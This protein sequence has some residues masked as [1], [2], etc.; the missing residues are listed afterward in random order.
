[1]KMIPHQLRTLLAPN[2]RPLPGGF[3]MSS[4]EAPRNPKSETGSDWY[5]KATSGYNWLSNLS[6]EE[7]EAMMSEGRWA[8]RAARYDIPGPTRIKVQVT[9]AP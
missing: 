4:S 8:R 3:D 9:L 1:M 2:R 7:E 6:P 5:A